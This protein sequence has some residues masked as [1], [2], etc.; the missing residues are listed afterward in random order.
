MI[1]M[2]DEP[3]A[4][5][6][7]DLLDSSMM[8]QY[9]SAAREQYN[10]AMQEQ[11]DFAKEFGDIYSPSYNLNKAYYDATKG[12][13][14]KA[15]DYLYK[16]GIDPIRS[17]EGRAYVAKIIRERPYDK[18][19]KWKADADNMKTYQKAAA[20]MVADGKLTQD[21]LNWQMQ[22]QGLDYDKFDPYTQSWNQLAPTKMDTLEEL[23]KIPY[24]VLK[25][26]NLTQKQVESMGYKYNPLNDYTG[27]TD[28]MIADTAGKSIP[29]V[30][31]TSAG[32]YY[33]DK[34]KQQLQQAGVYNPTDD[35]I[36]QQLQNTVA[37]LWEG[38]RTIAWDPNKYA[39]LNYQNQLA[40]QLDAK[41]SARDLA[42]QKAII[43]YKYADDVRRANNP[44]IYNSSS[45][46]R[47]GRGGKPNNLWT[48]FDVAY[49]KPGQSAG[50]GTTDDYQK[51]GVAFS[52]P[53]VQ[54]RRVKTNGEYQTVVTFKIGDAHPVK[55]GGFKS[56]GTTTPPWKKSMKGK[57][58][59]ATVIGGLTYNAKTGKYYVRCKLD[60][61]S[62]Q[63][64]ETL[65]K[66]SG[67]TDFWLPVNETHKGSPS[68]TENRQS[69]ND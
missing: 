6:I 2:Y 10:Q 60:N 32:E 69:P 50:L 65:R 3:V 41:K 49:N 28:Q 38:K 29:S 43:D 66:Q 54:V 53:G 21:Q 64:D 56:D 62:E 42:S 13:V 14:N 34:A 15:M 33:Y 27:I 16:N 19:S 67:V 63:T 35:Q 59:N 8:S 17:A 46:S 52:D 18:I 12:A 40:D 57:Q 1:G 23:T 61:T 48:I 25:P 39:I 26:S 20:A 24:S 55:R 47:S 31:S 68:N 58:V 22:K 30:M 4:V 51:E 11:K 9:I 7:L 37:Q 36:K 5:P 44:S 45:S